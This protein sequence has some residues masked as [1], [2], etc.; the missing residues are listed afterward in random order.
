[1]Q[2]RGKEEGRPESFQNPWRKFLSDLDLGFRALL[3]L[4]YMT[5]G[6]EL[7]HKLV[8]SHARDQ[9]LRHAEQAFLRVSSK[10]SRSI[11]VSRN[12]M[13]LAK[14]VVSGCSK[15]IIV[16]LAALGPS[17]LLKQLHTCS[18]LAQS[19]YRLDLSCAERPN[20]GPRQWRITWKNRQ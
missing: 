18:C 6:W 20:A 11:K 1:M 2:I 8:N 19:L 14:M 7:G 4:V 15:S 16:G 5:S 12:D 17:R 9:L 13:I 3:D 10:R